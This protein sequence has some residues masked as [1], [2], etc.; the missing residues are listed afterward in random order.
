MKLIPCE[1]EIS[2]YCKH[3]ASKMPRFFQTRRRPRSKMLQVP[4]KNDLFS[5]KMLR[6]ACE[7]EILGPKW[8]KLYILV[9]KEQIT[10]KVRQ[11]EKQNNKKQLRPKIDVWHWCFGTRSPEY[12]FYSNFLHRT[13]FTVWSKGLWHSGNTRNAIK[14]AMVLFSLPGIFCS[15]RFGCLIKDSIVSSCSH[16]FSFPHFSITCHFLS[17]VSKCSKMWFQSFRSY[18]F[19]QAQTQFVPGEQKTSTQLQDFT[20]KCERQLCVVNGRPHNF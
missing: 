4:S 11:T 5:S 7:C 10:R 18:I 19:L 9:P 8:S 2:N 13:V 12:L 15:Y 17:C 1:Y 14:Q 16:N 20:K 3:D 6:I